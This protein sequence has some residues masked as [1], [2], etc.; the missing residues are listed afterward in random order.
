[1]NENEAMDEETRITAAE[2]LVEIHKHGW[3]AFATSDTI[4]AYGQGIIMPEVV[5]EADEDGEYSSLKIL[6]WLGY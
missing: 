4:L 1:M 5:C 2:A 3:D 6:Q